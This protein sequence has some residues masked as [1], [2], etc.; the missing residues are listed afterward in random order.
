MNTINV[1]ENFAVRTTTEQPAPTKRA[2]SRRQMTRDA[3]GRIVYEPRLSLQPV[4]NN[5]F[6]TS[7]V[8]RVNGAVMGS[9]PYKCRE[10]AVKEL[11]RLA[12]FWW[13]GEAGTPETDAF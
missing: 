5:T 3:N 9:M 2:Y 7:Y 6:T 1:F 8:L 13:R 10:D 12:R 4:M 11:R